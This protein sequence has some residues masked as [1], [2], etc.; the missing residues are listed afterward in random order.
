MEATREGGRLPLFQYHYLSEQT[1][2]LSADLLPTIV[3]LFLFYCI[4]FGLSYTRVLQR[5]ES[6]F[7]TVNQIL[8]SLT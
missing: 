1:T 4:I 5:N 7:R 6:L 8:C 2:F 3:L